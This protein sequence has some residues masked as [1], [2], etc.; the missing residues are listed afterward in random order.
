[1]TIG[2]VLNGSRAITVNHNVQMTIEVVLNG[3][4]A[5]TVNT[6]QKRRGLRGCF[7]TPRP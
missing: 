3:H 5:I 1:M 7:C 6:V 4:Y 2:V